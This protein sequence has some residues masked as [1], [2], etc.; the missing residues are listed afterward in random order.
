M[1]L[2]GQARGLL[3]LLVKNRRAQ[4]PTI[5]EFCAQN[6]LSRKNRTT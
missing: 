1:K 6:L 4:N 2:H 5:V 3:V